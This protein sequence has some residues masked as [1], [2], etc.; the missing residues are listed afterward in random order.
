MKS[1][2]TSKGINNKKLFFIKTKGIL[3]Y[4]Y[5]NLYYIIKLISI[6]IIILLLYIIIK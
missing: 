3:L 1:S 4:C 6:I 2:F 5:N